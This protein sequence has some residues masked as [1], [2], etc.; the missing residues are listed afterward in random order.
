M[1]LN[2]K[3]ITCCKFFMFTHRVKT[4]I[5]PPCKLKSNKKDNINKE[6]FSQ[7]HRILRDR[8]PVVFPNIRL[9]LQH[10]D[11]HAMQWSVPA[12]SNLYRKSSLPQIYHSVGDKEKNH[13]MIP[14]V[15]HRWFHCIANLSLWPDRRK[16]DL[17]H[18]KN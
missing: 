10:E 18:W 4:N 13:L 9:I 17:N 8:V 6:E 2:T 11:W 15:M 1:S 14:N 5:L 12:A 7:C 16:L 3:F